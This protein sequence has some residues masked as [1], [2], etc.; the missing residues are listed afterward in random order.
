[1][2]LCRCGAIVRAECERCK[3]VRI[4][5]GTTAERGYDHRWRRLSE[6]KR[7]EDPLCEECEREGMVTPATEVHHI[8]P[9]RLAPMMRLSWSNIVSVCK[10]C[11]ERLEREAGK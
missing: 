7:Q 11:H 8:I 10:A 4:L 1:M 9:V 5:N 2:R 3:P 6:L